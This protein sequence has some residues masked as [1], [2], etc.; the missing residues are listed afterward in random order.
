M[1]FTVLYEHCRMKR[2]QK[3]NVL[4]PIIWY[5]QKAIEV[6][7]LGSVQLMATVSFVN[8]RYCILRLLRQVRNK[9]Y[10]VLLIQIY[11]FHASSTVISY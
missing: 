1:G 7:L 3:I 9:C 2:I 5:C 4:F 6:S 8:V 11:L 10:R